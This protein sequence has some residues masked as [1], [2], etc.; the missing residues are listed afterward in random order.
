MGWSS[1][2]S[3][4][5]QFCTD[6]SP[7]ALWL[8]SSEQYSV[9]R[10]SISCS[11][12][13]HSPER[14]WIEVAFPCFTVVK[15]FTSLTVV[16]PQSFFSLTTLFFY[17]VFFC[18]FHAPLVLSFTSL[19]FSDHSDFNIFFLGS[20]LLLHRLR[21]AEEQ[22]GLRAGRSTT[23]QNLQP[24]TFL[25]EIFPAPTRPLPCLHR[26]QDDLRLGLAFSFVDNHEEV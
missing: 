13:K 15:S 1:S 4:W 7:L 11:S 23:E 22:P 26:L 8:Y 9:H 14:S 19:Y 6:G 20:L 16:L 2:V 5:R 3:V 10:F 17:P 25:W 12:E 18:L 24:K 21:I